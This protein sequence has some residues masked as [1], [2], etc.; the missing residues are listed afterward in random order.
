MTRNASMVSKFGENAAAPLHTVKMPKVSSMTVLR[1][2]FEKSRAMI[3]AAMAT[4]SAKPLT[5]SD[6]SATDTS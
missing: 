4:T 3:G 6:A 1:F 5:R 2:T